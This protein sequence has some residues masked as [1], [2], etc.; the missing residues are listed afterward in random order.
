MTWSTLPPQST[1]H[2]IVPGQE[3]HTHWNINR[4]VLHIY[5]Q[6]FSP[7]DNTSLEQTTSYSSW[8]S[9]LGILQEEAVWPSNGDFHPSHALH[10]NTEC[11]AVSLCQ[12]AQVP[13]GKEVRFVTLRWAKSGWEQLSITSFWLCFCLL[14]TRWHVCLFM[15][16]TSKK[17]KGHT[18]FRL[19]VCASVR[20]SVQ[21]TFWCML[22][23]MN[24]AC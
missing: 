17:L 6:L 24:C 18:G 4:T 22:Y 11:W 10:P 23:L 12:V 2:Q 15:P 13:S 16:P 5:I 14:I 1:L 7:K 19:S 21:D 3:H 8:G 20:V 9:L